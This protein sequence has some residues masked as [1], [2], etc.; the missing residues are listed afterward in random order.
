MKRLLTICLLLISICSLSVAAEA[1]YFQLTEAGSN[2]RMIRI[3]NI[4]GFSSLSSS[5]FENPAGLYR[6]NS[7]SASLFNTTFMSEVNYQNISF[8]Y[9]LPVGMLAFGYMK[10]GVDDIKSTYATGS[11]I[12][13]K[14]GSNGTFNYRNSL[15]KV[16]YQVS[17]FENLH[18]GL[19]G[20]YY[21][22][23]LDK[24]SGN[25]FNFD[26][27]AILGSETFQ[28]SLVFRNVVNGM[29]VK[30]TDDTDFSVHTYLTEEEKEEFDSTGKTE[31]LPFMM[32]IG[33]KKKF[34]TLTF[35]GQHK[36]IENHQD[37]AKSYGVEYTPRFLSIFKI[38]GA[39][40]KYPVV[41]SDEG[42]T[43]RELDTT[44]VMGL[45][46]DLF[47]V[48][49]DYAHETSDHIEFKHKHY[50]SVGYSF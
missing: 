36:V 39:I 7:F 47:G 16:A 15:A 10:L 22:T 30:Y 9:R 8:G 19:A 41:R 20:S 46:I 5:I 35:Y 24:V 33:L 6:V 28:G 37:A 11:G 48:S 18:V 32:V 38:S 26:I 27:G 29:K 25:G 43:K 44:K 23:E 4:E 12:D 17:I 49:F 21:V 14:F 40:K 45:G 31:K 50:F 42:E 13:D 34:N 1:D 3:G 2:A